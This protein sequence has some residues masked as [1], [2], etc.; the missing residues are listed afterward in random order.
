MTKMKYSTNYAGYSV[1]NKETFC[2]YTWTVTEYNTGSVKF[3]TPITSVL[4][5]QSLR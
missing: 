2:G 3:Q 1:V 4:I 5:K